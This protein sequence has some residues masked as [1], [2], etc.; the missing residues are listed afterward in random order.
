LIGKTD[1]VID[2]VAKLVNG[3]LTWEG[4]SKELEVYSG[5]QDVEDA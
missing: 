5:V 3:E 1:Q 4:A 2:V